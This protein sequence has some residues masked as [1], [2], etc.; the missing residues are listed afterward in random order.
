M[1]FGR[2]KKSICFLLMIC[3]LFLGMCFESIQTDSSFSCEN[4]TYTVSTIRSAERTTLTKQV[5]YDE[6]LA[7]EESITDSQQAVR[8]L[9][10]RTSRG[11][12]LNL[13]FVDILPQISPIFYTSLD[14]ELAQE[15]SSNTII[16]NYI[17]HKDGKKA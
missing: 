10:T 9:F 13:A 15:S 5:Y 1:N 2:Q 11:I 8:R 7:K 6:T 4:T 12:A 3:M 17:H 16:V 14:C